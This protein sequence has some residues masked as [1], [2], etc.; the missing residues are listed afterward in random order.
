[1]LVRRII[2][3]TLLAA[4]AVVIGYL[5]YRLMSGWYNIVPW[6]VAALST[7]FFSKCRQG[8][9]INGAIFGYFLFMAYIWLGYQGKTDEASIL[10]FILFD[11]AFSLVGAMA[12][13]IGARLGYVIRMAAHY[14]Q[15]KE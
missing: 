14:G 13:S 5:S 2:I 11:L 6:A 9:L 1:M 15:T 12:G 3:R 10:H 8:S 4:G 7:G